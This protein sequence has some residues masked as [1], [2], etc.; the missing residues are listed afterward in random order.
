MEQFLEHYGLLAL[1][2]GMWVEGETVLVIA[3]FLIHQHLLHRW[4]AIP[5]AVLGALS[6]DHVLYFSGRYASRF[7][8]LQ[9]IKEKVAG[10][11]VG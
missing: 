6:V 10:T 7:K 9:K 2:L 1:Y 5:V 3:G 4:T 8:F 11:L